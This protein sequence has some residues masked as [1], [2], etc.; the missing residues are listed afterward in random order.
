MLDLALQPR[1]PALLPLALAPPSA[2]FLLEGAQPL[3]EPR[4]LLLEIPHARLARLRLRNRL[5]GR[6]PR[7]REL[8]VQLPY[9][10]VLG[11][12]LPPQRLR[13]R[14]LRVSTIPPGFLREV[15]S[16]IVRRE[17][18]ALRRAV[19][20]F[21]PVRSVRFLR[22]VPVRPAP[23]RLLHVPYSP[24]AGPASVPPPV[25]SWG[26]AAPLA[27]PFRAARRSARRFSRS[28]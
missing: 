23:V 28:S 15:L 8:F 5:V 24:P 19:R 21:G 22:I 3:L 27:S 18:V 2:L 16:G 20:P 14:N 25:S 7:R 9:V 12:E 13:V 11:P 4:P 10:P 6:K 1:H 26:S 17:L